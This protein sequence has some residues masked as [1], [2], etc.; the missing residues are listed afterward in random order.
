[1]I[2]EKID[3]GEDTEETVT[4]AVANAKGLGT[5]DFDCYIAMEGLE[6]IYVDGISYMDM[7]DV[8][9]KSSDTSA[10]DMMA[11]FSVDVLMGVDFEAFTS[12]KAQT[13]NS[14]T[15][16]TLKGV[17]EKVFIEEVLGLTEDLFESA[18][19]YEEVLETIK[20]DAANY[21]ETYTID[22]D[23]N[24][25]GYTLLYS[26]TE[27]QEDKSEVVYSYV[28]INTISTSVAEI[29]VPEDA[30]SYIGA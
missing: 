6:I 25:T 20:C 14:D 19:I 8:K 15:L 30:D 4:Q 7:M 2:T 23:G 29:T 3:S 16:L 1:M 21:T 11:S 5:D 27:I 24:V 22:K 26:Y 13:L 10:E 17:S 28:E 18:D 9:I 12:V